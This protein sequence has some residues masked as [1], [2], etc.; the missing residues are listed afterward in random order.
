MTDGQDQNAPPLV[1]KHGERIAKITK[2]MKR[3]R[4]LHPTRKSY[5]I[6]TGKRL[7]DKFTNILKI[8]L[9]SGTEGMWFLQKK[10]TWR[11]RV[12]GILRM[13]KMIPMT[14]RKEI[15]SWDGKMED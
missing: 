10:G 9:L 2:M 5:A 1:D 3:W 4:N 7:A 8:G 6:R 13:T 15:R 14:I 11:Q 12:T